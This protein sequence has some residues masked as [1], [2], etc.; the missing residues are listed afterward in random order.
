MMTVY[1]LDET[2]G[3]YGFGNSMGPFR[4]SASGSAVAQD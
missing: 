2:G 4:A 1:I 3:A